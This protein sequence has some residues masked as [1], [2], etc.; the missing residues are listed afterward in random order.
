MTKSNHSSKR[1]S[2]LRYYYWKKHQEE[3]PSNIILFL[4]KLFLWIFS[5]NQSQTQ[6]SKDIEQIQQETQSKVFITAKGEIVKSRAEKEIADFL[7]TQK[8]V[9][10]YEKPRTIASGKVIHPDFYLEEYDVYIEYFGMLGDKKY[11]FT[12]ALKEDTFEKENMRVIKLYPNNYRN[13]GYTIKK[14]FEE[15]TH[16]TFP[17]RAFIPYHIV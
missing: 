7:Y 2:Y 11:N 17:Q 15:V 13:L 14:R 6:T 16:K 8:I 5:K 3:N 10:Q 4:K 12:I 9:Y 1:A